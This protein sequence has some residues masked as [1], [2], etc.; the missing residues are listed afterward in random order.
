[1][2]LSPSRWLLAA[3]LLLALGGA[4]VAVVDHR[5]GSSSSGTKG[6]G[7]PATRVREVAAFDRVE[8]A[9]TNNV[10]IHVGGRQRVV[11]EADDN[12]LGR[13]TTKVRTS[14]LVIANTP[15]S[16]TTRSPMRVDVTVPSLSGLTLSG[17]GNVVVSG[18]EAD[19]F[20]VSLA[21]SGTLTGSGAA[22]RL[23][24]TVPGSGSVE[25]IPVAA[26]DVRAAVSGSGS[27]FVTATE[28]LDASVSGSGAIVY[29]GHPT[30]VT[31]KVTGSGAITGS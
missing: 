12:L 23:D 28:R 9:G 7:V 13:V 31:K 21:G 5:N 24:I 29:A 11:V 6:S 18:V 2:T 19:R 4:A 22:T 17:S 8:L 1:M 3:I 16:F 26:K 27:I 30:A 15:G 25:F 10:M 14:T 20:D